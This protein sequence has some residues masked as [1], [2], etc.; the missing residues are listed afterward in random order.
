MLS[1]V[2]ICVIFGGCVEDAGDP[3]IARVYLGWTLDSGTDLFTERGNVYKPF[4]IVLT[5]L[6]PF[7]GYTGISRT[8]SHGS[9]LFVR[10][11]GDL[12]HYTTI[13][14]GNGDID[15]LRM[16]GDANDV[17]ESTEVDFFYNGVLQ[18]SWDVEKQVATYH[19][20]SGRQE[21]LPMESVIDNRLLLLKDS[22]SMA[23]IGFE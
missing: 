1:I 6:P 8:H 11:S 2:L 16:I 13:D 23:D 21:R 7:G 18:V 9:F 4:D 5:G 17:Y 19:Y 15:T 12:P 20:D 22:A 14:F 3:P 10:P